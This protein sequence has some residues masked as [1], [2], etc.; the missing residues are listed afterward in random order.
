MSQKPPTA[1]KSIAKWLT[2]H[3]TIGYA[4]IDQ[5]KHFSPKDMKDEAL[6]ENMINDHM[7]GYTGC[8]LDD[9]DKKG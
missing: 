1:I 4:V 2:Y 5:G 3:V 6:S 9:F 7:M 8:S